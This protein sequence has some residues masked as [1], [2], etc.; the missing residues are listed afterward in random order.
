MKGYLKY[1]YVKLYGFIRIEKYTSYTFAFI[2]GMNILTLLEL[3]IF[4]KGYPHFISLLVSFLAMIFIV[5]ILQKRKKSVKI[6]QDG[7]KYRNRKNKVIFWLHMFLSIVIYVIYLYAGII[8]F[9]Q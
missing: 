7:E 8:G 4:R 3:V 2:W 1:M 9:A 5:F 6:L